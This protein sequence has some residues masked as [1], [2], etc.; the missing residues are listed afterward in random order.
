[1][2]FSEN[3]KPHIPYLRRYARLL[4]GDQARGDAIVRAALES[5]VAG[6]TPIDRELPPRVSLYKLFHDN[7]DS[8]APAS[9]A[10]ATAQ[11]RLTRIPPKARQA[12]VLTAVEG[13]SVRDTA[14]I[15]G[16]SAEDVDRLTVEAQRAIDD[17]LRTRVLI[18]EDEPVV[19][20]DI[21]AIVTDSGHEVTGV[22]RTRQEAVDMFRTNDVQLVLADIQLADG[23]SG[24]D[25]VN[26]ILSEANVP[27]IFI[28]AYPERLLTGE[29]PEPT[30]L[31]TKPFMPETVAAT[32]GQVLF[33]FEPAEPTPAQ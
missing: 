17:G 13:F 15:L 29:R 24:I 4:T 23:S 22:A 2:P 8:D 3:V 26:D 16:V 14:I 11:D 25:A 7:W 28:T 6:I 19:A 33:F 9:S 20:L 32:I 18:I 21:E 10:Q 30:Y 5:A 12:L 1:M 27:V 31:I